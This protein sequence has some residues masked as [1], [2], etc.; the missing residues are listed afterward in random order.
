MTVI[1]VSISAARKTSV[2]NICFT[3]RETCQNVSLV[4]KLQGHGACQYSFQQQMFLS[5]EKDIEKADGFDMKS[6]TPNVVAEVCN[7]PILK[8]TSLILSPPLLYKEYFDSNTLIKMSESR[9]Y[10]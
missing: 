2:V 7:P 1:T 4:L 8:S 10:L 6:L 9:I 5:T 3:M